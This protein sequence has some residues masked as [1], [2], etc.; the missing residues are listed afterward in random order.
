M[1]SLMFNDKNFENFVKAALELMCV[2]GYNL[3]DSAAAVVVCDIGGYKSRAKSYSGNEAYVVVA[4][5]GEPLAGIL[6]SDAVL[7]RYPLSLVGLR[8]AVASAEKIAEGVKIR[9]GF[10]TVMYDEKRRVVLYRGEE[11]S[12]TPREGRL[13]EIL[14]E[15]RGE[16]IS[17][18]VLR[19]QVFEIYDLSGVK[20]SNV[21]DVYVNYLRKRLAPVFGD[22]AIATVRGKGY[23]LRI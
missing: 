17:R 3:L 8:D 10:D 18:D 5:D 19:E 16:T 22:V 7:V 2:G 11:V 20:N 1:V 9:S 23:A 12:L 21:V 14:F 13:F 15:H 6:D 4:G